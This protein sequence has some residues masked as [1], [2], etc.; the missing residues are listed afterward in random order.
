M[1]E[2]AA[3]ALGSAMVAVYH[4]WV[5]E[6]SILNDC[7]LSLHLLSLLGRDRFFLGVMGGKSY[8]KDVNSRSFVAGFQ[9]L[10]DSEIQQ[11]DTKTAARENSASGV[12]FGPTRTVTG[13]REENDQDRGMFSRID[14]L[15]ESREESLARTPIFHNVIDTITKSREEGD[16]DAGLCSLFVFPR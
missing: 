5:A 2:N 12:S 13:T 9:E 16:Q 3:R 14:T 10:E 1:P 6:I 4:Q 15:T 11:V 8:V 7:P